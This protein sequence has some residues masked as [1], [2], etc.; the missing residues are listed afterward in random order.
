MIPAN[1]YIV[2]RSRD[3]KQKPLTC[4]LGAQEI[5][6]FRTSTGIGALDAHC[7]HLGTHLQHATIEDD[8]LVCPLHR[9]RY[10]A[11]GHCQVPGRCQPSFPVRERHGALF[12][13][14]EPL[15]EM[16][17][18]PPFPTRVGRPWTL[19][20]PWQAVAANGFDAQHLAQVHGRRVVDGP[21]VDE[22][23][24]KLTVR[25]RSEVIGR[26]LADRIARRL[27][28]NR[29]EVK[30]TCFRGTWL[31][32]ESRFGRWRSFLIVSLLPQDDNTCQA[33]PVYGLE[34]RAG[35]QLGWWLVR[36]F[37]RQDLEVLKDIRWQPRL[38]LPQDALLQQLLTF[39]ARV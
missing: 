33:W 17:E 29:I 20:T 32:M 2:A 39:L 36:S 4:R 37:L 15:A 5:V 19:R 23:P 13:A 22:A 34:S 8:R 26:T 28:G 12:V 11:Q 27:T 21:H 3:L 24:D 31:A 1:W 14:L 10:T 35:L 25:Y 7:S 16:P 6:L 30:L 9:W 18:M 38:Q